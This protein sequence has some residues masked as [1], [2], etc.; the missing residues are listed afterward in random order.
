MANDQGSEESRR[1]APSRIASATVLVLLVFGGIAYGIYSLTS[2]SGSGSNNNNPLSTS[3][4]QHLTSPKPRSS[5]T[6]SVTNNNSPSTT[7]KSASGGS[8]VGAK[9]SDGV[10]NISGT[11]PS[12]SNNSSAPQSNQQLSNTGPGNI[13]MI[14]FV[15]AALLGTI[16]HYG[17][18]K[19]R[20][21]LSF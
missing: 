17:W 21:N 19:L 8:S 13:A 3:N 18:R 16:A 11:A 15:V 20:S 2:S 9:T 12:V 1:W 14:G 7:N 5:N 4:N 10:S 6:H